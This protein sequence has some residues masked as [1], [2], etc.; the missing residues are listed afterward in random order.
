MEALGTADY[1]FLSGLLE[2]LGNGSSRGG[3]VNEKLLNFMLAVIKGIEPRDQIESGMKI[4]P[5]SEILKRLRDAEKLERFREERRRRVASTSS[6]RLWESRGWQPRLRT[7]GAGRRDRPS[8]VGALIARGKINHLFCVEAVRVRRND[9]AVDDDVVDEAG[10]HGA[11]KA[12]IGYLYRRRVRC[13][14][15][16]PA[17]LGESL[18]IDCDIDL[19][20]ADEFGRREITQAA[21]FEEAVESAT[22]AV[23]CAAVVFRAKR[24][25]DHLEPAAV[26]LLDQSRKQVGGRVIVEIRRQ[27]GKADAVVVVARRR[28][29]REW[30]GKLDRDAR[31]RAQELVLRRGEGEDAVEGQRGDLPTSY[32]LPQRGKRLSKARLSSS[33]A[34]SCRWGSPSLHKRQSIKSPGWSGRRRVARP[35]TYGFRQYTVARS[36]PNVRATSA[37]ASPAAT[38][39][40]AS[41]RWCAVSF[42]GR[43]KRTPRTLAR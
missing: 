30:A 35:A 13:K 5:P 23:L 6:A 2:Q 16:R 42:F 40:T 24:D 26:V 20:R 11:G 19:V 29:Q 37:T 3:K 41:R 12:E 4:W 7:G 36:I 28:Q 21:H 38:R 10:A 43:P 32:P 14:N 17:T 15:A 33:M 34:R 8:I 18:E 39:S 1:D 31:P 27:I 9:P 22:D 25:P